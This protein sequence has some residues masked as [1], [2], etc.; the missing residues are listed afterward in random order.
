MAIVFRSKTYQVE[1]DKTS[2]TDQTETFDSD[3]NRA[4]GVISAINLTFGGDTEKQ[5]NTI[6]AEV[7]DVRTNPGSSVVT[8]NVD[9]DMYDDGG[10]GSNSINGSTIG[11]V[12]IAD[13]KS[14]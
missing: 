14:A 10:P 13:I 6:Q 11:V 7:S 1:N 12:I 4:V 3:V 9:L 8:Y 5:I 2:W